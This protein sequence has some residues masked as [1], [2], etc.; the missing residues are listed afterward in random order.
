MNDISAQ[1]SH[2]FSL[3]D[4]VNRLTYTAR[5]KSKKIVFLLGAP[6]SAPRANKNGVPD[7]DGVIDL[8]RQEFSGDENSISDLESQLRGSAKNAYQAAMGFLQ[9]RRGQDVVNKIITH[10]VLMARTTYNRDEAQSLS[11]DES[12]LK[13]VDEN[14]AEWQLS[15]AHIQLAALIRTYPD[16]F[17]SV[18][19]TTNFD[20]LIEKALDREGV[21]YYTTKLSRDGDL[22]QTRSSGCHVVHLHGYWHGSDTLHTARQLT[23]HRPRLKASLAHILRD[24]IVVVVAYG[25]WDDTFTRT[26]IEVATEDAAKPE[27]IWTFFNDRT[28]DIISSNQR[29]LEEIAPA[30]DRGRVTL[31]KGIDCDELFLA[32]SATLLPSLSSPAEILT[33]ITENTLGIGD[34]FSHDITERLE[35]YDPSDYIPRIDKIYGRD[36]ELEMLKNTAA[37]VVTISG[38]GGQGKSALAAYFAQSQKNGNT[39]F[40]FVEWCDCRELDDMLQGVLIHLIVKLSGQTIDIES[41]TGLQYEALVQ[42]FVEL[43]KGKKGIIVFDN[44]DHYVD[45]QNGSPLNGV[46]LIMEA[47]LRSPTKAKLIFTSRPPIRLERNDVLAFSLEGLSKPA[48]EA[49][50]AQV[51]S[52]QLSEFDLDSLW[53]ITNGHPLW[54]TLISGQVKMVGVTVAILIEN[55]K[56]GNGDLPEKTLASMWSNLTDKQQSLLRTIAELERPLAES[57]IGEIEASLNFNQFTKAI[58]A[59]K[60]LHLISIR[61]SP[62][63]KDVVDLHPLIREHVRKHFPR[64]Q[65]EKFISRIVRALDR[66]L[67]EFRVLFKDNQFPASALNVW[68]HKIDISINA[69]DYGNAIDSLVEIESALES[70]GLSDESIRLS[71]RIFESVD[72]TSFCKSSKKFNSLWASAVK[73]MVERETCTEADKYLQQY[74]DSIE[75]AGAQFINYCSVRCYRYWF[76]GDF[77][78]AIYWGEKGTRLK[79]MS[80]VDIDY[81]CGHNLALARRDGGRVA[82]ALK[83]FL[84]ISTEEEVLAN[85]SPEQ[86]KNGHFYG[87]IG[88]CFALNG[89]IEKALICYRKS[90]Q[91]TEIKHDSLVNFGYIRYWVAQAMASKGRYE[92]AV[93]FF[94]AAI[95][96]WKGLVPSM[97]DTIAQELEGHIEKYPELERI[98]LLPSWRIENRFS[99]WMNT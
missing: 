37:T 71:K 96:K 72:W 68:T 61:T 20:P 26:L 50:F 48:C 97:A 3:D 51:S 1:H 36:T 59:L 39:D 82:E 18:I 4:L 53:T 31:F 85:V 24:S 98:K 83:H 21:N 76:T 99:E 77:D 10:A 65:R 78:Q 11:L 40:E 81:D 30:I 43:I 23:Q 52:S 5:N 69:G 27:L 16:S 66:R 93:I 92:E 32:L 70:G 14:H 49:L 22:A 28:Q 34:A 9:A 15:A 60:S 73:L 94:R 80:H 12:G 8:I 84:G 74:S 25:G 35:R 13:S 79:E 63:N 67:V 89:E 55:I 86:E 42:A 58:K 87:N 88:R 47:A 57:E 90:A 29:R 91:L 6:F 17:G 19:L 54:I 75:G 95:A 62:D 56:K 33:S 45:L 44:V 64:S 2:F 41:L 38:M 7:V 46:R